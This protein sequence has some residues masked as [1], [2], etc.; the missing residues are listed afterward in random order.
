MLRELFRPVSKRRK[1]RKRQ[2]L[3][4]L[5][6]RDLLSTVAPARLSARLLIN[7]YRFNNS[8]RTKREMSLRGSL[9]RLR[10]L[11]RFSRTTTTTKAN[12][13]L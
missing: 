6:R 9:Y 4:K 11:T 8:A 7:G 3:L 12:G 1:R 13:S 10:F 5:L 2:D